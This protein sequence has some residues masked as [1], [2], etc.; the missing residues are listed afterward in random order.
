MVI[1]NKSWNKGTA[2]YIKGL[3][4]MQA[5]T[6]KFYKNRPGARRLIYMVILFLKL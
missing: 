6:L 2:A 1:L 4:R 5:G 3:L